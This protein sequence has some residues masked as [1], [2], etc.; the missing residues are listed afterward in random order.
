MY[1]WDPLLVV[2]DAD[3]KV[4]R[5]AQGCW[6]PTGIPW[7]S[8]DGFL[9]PGLFPIEFGRGQDLEPGERKSPSGSA[10]MKS[11]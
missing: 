7:G 10:S 2:R 6:K 8:A 9:L 11:R 3:G 5:L 1:T 4:K